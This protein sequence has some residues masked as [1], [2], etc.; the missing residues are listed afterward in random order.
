MTKDILLPENRAPKKKISIN[1]EIKK[2]LLLFNLFQTKG[3]Q[4]KPKIKNLWIY[5]PAT[6]SLPNILELCFPKLSRPKIFFPV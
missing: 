5:E 1:T 2:Y 6:K 4:I 3:R